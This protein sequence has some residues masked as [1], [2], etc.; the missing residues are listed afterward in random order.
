MSGNRRTFRTSQLISPFGPGAIVDIG[1][2]SLIMNG[3][4]QWPP[5]L[6]RIELKRLTEATGVFHLKKAPPVKKNSPDGLQASRFPAWLFCSRCRKLEYRKASDEAVSA[7]GVPVCKNAACKNRTLVPMRF[8][9]ACNNGH[10]QDVP[11][12]KWAH[13]KSGGKCTEG[14]DARGQLY[15]E[16]KSGKGSGLDALKVTCRNPGCGSSQS[17]GSIMTP[18]TLPGT[19]L[20]KQPYE[21]TETLTPCSEALRVLQRGASNLYYGITKSALDIPVSA[22][23]EADP[24]IEKIKQISEYEDLLDAERRNKT[25]WAE[26]IATEIAET[27][28][29][30]MESVLKAIRGKNNEKREFK[31]PRDEDIRKAEWQ[32][33]TSEDPASFS[34]PL[35]KARVQQQP[36]GS[37]SMLSK[38]IRRVVLIDKLREVRAFCGFE[39]IKPDGNIIPATN[40]RDDRKWLPAAEV[41]GEGIFIELSNAQIRDWEDRNHSQL[42]ARLENIKAKHASLN[43]LYL[44][45]PSAKFIALHTFAHILI[46]QLTFESGYSA[47]SLRERIYAFDEDQA[48]IMIY[49]ADGDSEGSLGGLVQQGEYHRLYAAIESA[50]ETAQWCS[51]DPVCSEAETQGVMEMNKA[52]CHSC[53]L[54]SETGCEYNNLLLDRALLTGNDEGL[55]GLLASAAATQEYDK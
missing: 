17:L 21:Y 27:L 32:I 34:W 8:V 3:T 29:T 14:S 30:D 38:L 53:S 43:S 22:C 45:E 49:T 36:S 2:E 26:V 24:L 55:E 50:V 25:R 16:S 20:G 31:I 4:D 7:D 40:V 5:Q 28:G 18:S 35:F 52:A 51:N 10:L 42:S 19:C 23:S 41:F 1:E 9:A 39:R 15:F 33:L 46:R 54:I 11:W 6:E 37:P 48:G 44:P 12:D 47:S 13:K